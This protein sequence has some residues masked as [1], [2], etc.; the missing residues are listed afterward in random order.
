VL[1]IL[2]SGNRWIIPLVASIAFA[3]A[4]II[5]PAV[6]E[7]LLSDEQKR[8]L[9]ALFSR[10]S[11]ANSWEHMPAVSKVSSNEVL[12]DAKDAG[13]GKDAGLPRHRY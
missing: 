9:G 3:A 6:Y 1:L 5:V 4:V 10:K 7:Y 13:S 8:K 11:A 12:L 2:G